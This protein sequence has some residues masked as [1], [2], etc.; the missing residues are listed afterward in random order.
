MKES[1]RLEKR[2]PSRSLR[3]LVAD[4]DKDAV[5][6][7]STLLQQEGHEVLE[8]YR[9]DAVRNLVR[10]YK[11]DAV[12][13]D[14]GMPG[15]TGIEIAKQLVDEHGARCPLLVAIT[16]WKQPSAKRLGALAGFKHYL[17]KPY[18]F[19]ELLELLARLP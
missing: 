12:L 1:R 7:L 2:R 3:I 9:G 10:R 18:S 13:L 15:V 8:V 14:I 5:L 19:D 17:T 6:T 11:P 4:D 16:A